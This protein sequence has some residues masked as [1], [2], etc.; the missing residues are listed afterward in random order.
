VQKEILLTPDHYA[1]LEKEL[2]EL[3]TVRRREVAERIKQ[4]IEF[5]DLSE[6]SEYD[7][8][9]NEQARVEGQI[10]ELTEILSKAQ[11]IPASNGGKDK[12]DV[13]CKVTLIDVESGDKAVYQL[14]GS[15]EADPANHKI[16]NESP[17]GQAILGQKRGTIVKVSVPAGKLEYRIEKI[18]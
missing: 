5:G 17:V 12:V 9:K 16:S 10:L 6:N 15:V 4:S 8:A 14:V 7:D 3:V 13:G 18:G 2:D 11:L 1:K